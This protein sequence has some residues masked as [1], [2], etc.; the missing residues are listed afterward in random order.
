MLDACA[1][2]GRLADAEHIAYGR[3]NHPAAHKGECRRGEEEEAEGSGGERKKD[4][5]FVATR[6]VVRTALVYDVLLA[7]PMY[8]SLMGCSHQLHRPQLYQAGSPPRR[9]ARPQG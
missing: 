9:P 5:G 3:P 6:G 1:L 7:C 8:V 4:T 2:T